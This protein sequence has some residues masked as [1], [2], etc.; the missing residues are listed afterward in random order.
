MADAFHAK[1]RH[2]LAMGDEELA[3]TVLVW[4]ATGFV[5]R[6]AAYNAG[7]V[8]AAG[9]RRRREGVALASW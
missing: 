1:V 5:C 4:R 9:G 3:A 6:C 7:R 2:A 8:D